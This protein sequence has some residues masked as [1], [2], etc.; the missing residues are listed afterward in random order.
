MRE[1]KR[2]V[3]RKLRVAVDIVAHARSR[4]TIKGAVRP[5]VPHGARCLGRSVAWPRE[6]QGLSLTREAPTLQAV[7]ESDRRRFH[8]SQSAAD[9]DEQNQICRPGLNYTL[10]RHALSLARARTTCFASAAKMKRNAK[11]SSYED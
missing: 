3:D 9:E 2:Q 5:P 7:A 1:A 4:V 11:A 6:D 8:E 10:R